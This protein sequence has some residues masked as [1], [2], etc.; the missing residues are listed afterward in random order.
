MPEEEKGIKEEERKEKFGEFLKE[1]EE[2]SS[3]KEERK[4][5]AE[6]Y[7]KY[8]KALTK[9][10]RDTYLVFLDGDKKTAVKREDIPKLMVEDEIFYARYRNLF[11]E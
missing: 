6:S 11:K 5:V 9:S 10:D 8:L 3:T 4:R 7:K 2:V 1:I